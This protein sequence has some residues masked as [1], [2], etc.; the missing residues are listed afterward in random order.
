MKTKRVDVVQR[1]RV[2]ALALSIA[3]EEGLDAV[4]FRRLA[5]ELSVTPMA[6]YHLVHDKADL[7]AAMIDLLLAEVDLDAGAGRWEAR[8][9]AVLLSF[10]EAC[11]RHPCAADL[12]RTN[13]G[14]S[15]RG[16]ALLEAT[17]ALLVDAGFE[18]EE[19]LRIVWR[20]SALLTPTQATPGPGPGHPP[21][22]EDLGVEL[23]VLGVKGL[24]RR[25][26]RSPRRRRR[27]G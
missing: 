25:R 2:V 20:L 13:P 11:H 22:D 10:V 3:D 4:S 24:L 27:G 9:R 21:D 15:A 5:D 1:D 7:L 6:L 14:G 18:R 19:G 26:T 12:L 17:L 8:L 16:A 23:L